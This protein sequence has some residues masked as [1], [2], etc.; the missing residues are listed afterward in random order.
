MVPHAQPSQ[1]LHGPGAL[2]VEL[3]T[4][5]AYSGGRE[6]ELTR[7]S[8]D[9]LAYLVEHQGRVIPNGELI[10]AIWKHE[11][12]ED[13]RFLQTAMYRLRAALR[14]AKADDPI[15]VVRGVGYSIGR[16]DL[17]DSP[18]ALRDRSA[19]EAAIRGLFM[20]TMLLD[21]HAKIV[22]ANKAAAA[23]LRYGV[24]E[25]EQLSVW[26]LT[27]AA[28][29]S[30]RLQRFERV[31]TGEEGLFAALPLKLRDG[32]IT[33]LDVSAR[34]V[35]I[36]GRTVGAVA[37][38]LPWDGDQP[39]YADAATATRGLL[40]AADAA[41]RASRLPTLVIGDGG[42]VLLANE[43]AARLTGYSV[44]E[45][46]SLPATEVLSPPGSAERRGEGLAAIW[47]SESCEL[48]SEPLVQRDGSII[49]VG[50]V[51]EPFRSVT[52][53]GAVVVQLWPSNGESGMRDL[54][55]AV[56]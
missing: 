42:R 17:F 46:E 7:Q 8:F 30:R 6:I 22:V 52:G 56:Q 27:P 11:V 15:E 18:E 50:L 19:L 38:L 33:K 48:S 2:R 55:S 26:D 24:G 44:A 12:V 23:L 5:R 20:P 3:A 54:L 1:V 36:D 40:D 29:R 10:K 32:T 25:L 28:L 45:L 21:P 43:A 16:H 35:K 51:A 53:V 31:L 14:S 37:E 49:E 34:P 13:R 4:R 47:T 9:L 39:E 41:L